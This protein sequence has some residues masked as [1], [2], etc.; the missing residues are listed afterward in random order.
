M[1]PSPP[2]RC[3]RIPSI[4]TSAEG[5]GRG[6]RWRVAPLS[7]D[8]AVFSVQEGGVDSPMQVGMRCRGWGLLVGALVVTFLT[9]GAGSAASAQGASTE[10]AASA[11][12][13]TAST[14]AATS[15]QAVPQSSQAT[16][17]TGTASPIKHVVVIVEE[18]HS[19]DNI[20]GKFCADVEHG[21]IMRPGTD[22]RCDGVTSGLDSEGQQVPLAEASNT[23]PPLDHTVHGQAVDI[24]GGRMNGFDEN[25]PCT[26][27][28]TTCYSQFD[29]LSGP[30]PTGSCIPNLSTL[31]TRYTVSD[32]TFEFRASPSWAGHMEFAAATQDRFKGD[33]PELSNDPTLQPVSHGGGW[34]CDSGATAQW[35]DAIGK[36][37]TVPSCIPDK[38]GSLG[39][40]WV[41]YQGPHAKY[42]PTIFD[43]LHA[44]HLSWSIYGGNGK[45]TG[46]NVMQASGW[47]WAIC[48]TFAECLYSGQRTHLHPATRILKDAAGDNLPSFSMVTPTFSNS[49]HNAAFM[50]EGDNYLGQVVSSLES[51]P[52][53]GS[54]AAFITYDDCGCFYD[55]VNPLAYDAYWG[56]RVP[57]VIVSPWAKAGYTDSNPTTFAGILAFA[58][59]N[60]DVS[61]L[62]ASD[63]KAYDYSQ[64]FCYQPVQEGCQQAGPSQSAMVAQPAPKPTAAQRKAQLKA[65]QQDT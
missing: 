3:C 41:N 32:R 44:A 40:N 15:A 60:F 31:A 59:H 12:G 14:G 35:F 39:P 43:R 4:S 23:V 1:K 7:S 21:K 58:E 22:S 50:D 13:V 37:F 26:N 38:A 5:D 30:C 65:A 64:S 18:N 28:L 24:N 63:A 48:P 51:S 10:A 54:T 16:P 8:E 29:P 27:D 19:F 52:E 45:S 49:Q 56:V 57:M 20:L 55:H 25:Q 36:P 17:A 42:V 33:N 53:W 9:V 62:N 6:P 11:Q 34:G 2:C 61:P 46:P 47:Q